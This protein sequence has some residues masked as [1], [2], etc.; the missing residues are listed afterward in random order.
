MKLRKT[1][2][3]ARLSIAT[4]GL[5]TGL[6]LMAFT[7]AAAQMS[8]EEACKDDAFRLC[9]NFIPDRDKVGACLRQKSRSLSP[10][11]RTFVV[12]GGRHTT[13]RTR[14]HVRTRTY[15]HTTKHK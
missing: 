6:A 10:A 7:P 12:G 15:H 4:A 11:C 8:P 9:G 13:G 14:T 3:V 2:R 1:N 5:L